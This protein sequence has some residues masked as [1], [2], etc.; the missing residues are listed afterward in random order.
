VVNLVRRLGFLLK[1]FHKLARPNA[2][3]W[4]SI[5]TFVKIDLQGVTMA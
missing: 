3:H 4:L 2:L 1:L 5:A